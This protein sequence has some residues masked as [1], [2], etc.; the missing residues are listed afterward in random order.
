MTFTVEVAV[1][2]LEITMR[3]LGAL[4]SVAA[5]LAGLFANPSPCQKFLSYAI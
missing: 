2:M 1:A 5:D 4:R 3:L